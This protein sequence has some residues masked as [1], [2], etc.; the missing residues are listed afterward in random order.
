MSSSG[1][2]SSSFHNAIRLALSL[3]TDPEHFW[4]LSALVI[5]GDAVLTKLIISFIPY[6]EIDWETYMIQTKI[7]LSGEHDYSKISGPTG[8]LVYP[9]GH[10]RIHHLL[11]DLTNAGKNMGL[12]QNLYGLLTGAVPNW[13]VLLLPLSK[14]LHSIFVL[15]LFND[16]WAVVI[17]QLAILACQY[18]YDDTSF[19]LFS[20]A[21]SVKMSVLLYFPGLLVISFKRRGPSSTFL[22]MVK[23]AAT[24]V[25]F[26]V[27]FLKENP[28]SYA[29]GAF[30]LGRV[31]LYKWTVNW[32]FLDEQTFLEP[33][34]ALGL[35]IGHVTVLVAFAWFRWCQ[36]DGG[37]WSVLARGLK[38]PLL[39][40]G[41]ATVTPDY[42]AT[43]LFTSNLIGIL[44][45]RSLHYQFYSWYAQQLP[46]LA[47]RTRYPI[48]V[49]VAIMAAIECSWNV[50]PST[51]LSSSVLLLGNSLLLIGLWFGHASGKPIQVSAGSKRS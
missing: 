15:R 18:G 16:C 22:S 9:A 2:L 27:P 14:R 8:P 40:A 41:L 44:F 49:R 45:A 28:W 48:V 33:K 13:I 11:Y 47:W 25:L 39:P 7:Y 29:R 42:V 5:L 10:V 35:L 19:L 20:A 30:D 32:R 6:T 43:V 51:G 12:A 37:T 26:A 36:P 34:L 31:F 4:K 21:L 1:W 23:V 24:Q 3:L 17:S 38:R 50:F 46:F